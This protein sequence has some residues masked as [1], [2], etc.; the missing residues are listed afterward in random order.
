M[1]PFRDRLQKPG[2]IV[3]VHDVRCAE[4]Q[5]A[6]ILLIE[7]FGGGGVDLR[8]LD[9]VG[10]AILQDDE[11]DGLG[12]VA[13]TDDLG[14]KVHVLGSGEANEDGIRNFD[15]T[16]VD[17]IGVNM[18]DIAG[19]DVGEDGR[20]NKGLIDAA[21]AIRGDGD[22]GPRLEDDLAFVGDARENTLFEKNN[23]L[24]FETEVVVLLKEFLR[25]T[26]GGTRGHDVP[27][28]H[29]L[30]FPNFQGSKLLDSNDSL[31]LE[32][33]EGFFGGKANVEAAFRGGGAES[34]PLAAYNIVSVDS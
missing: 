2:R 22:S 26:A 8:V 21:I 23:I 33:E 32:L 4:L 7:R 19:F 14:G 31:S 28:H 17:A 13:F 12:R 30:L 10:L 18:V 6:L 27:R 15:E 3:M 11:A 20:G 24:R 25:G 5:D 16:V 1:H 9:N 29:C 34:G